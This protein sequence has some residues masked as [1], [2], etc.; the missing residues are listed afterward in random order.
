MSHTITQYFQDTPVLFHD[1]GY[2]NATS[3][4]KLFHKRVQ[5]YLKSE[6]TQDYIFALASSEAPNGASEENQLVI[7]Q[8]GGVSGEQGTWL[9]PK[10]AIDFA[11]WLNAR[12]AVWCDNQIAEIINPTAPQPVGHDLPE[13]DVYKDKYIALLETNLQQ[14]KQ[15]VKHP[16]TPAQSKPLMEQTFQSMEY[17]DKYQQG[18][19]RQEKQAIISLK[20]QGFPIAYIAHQFKRTTGGIRGVLRRAK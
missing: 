1:N 18:Y 5:K 11:R 6:R 4:A 12:F 20:E 17:S 2:L 13:E 7:I 3:I 8:K 19:S 9:H 16:P 14:L 10:L 15:A